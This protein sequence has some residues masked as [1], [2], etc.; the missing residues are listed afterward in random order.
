MDNETRIANAK[1]VLEIYSKDIG[2]DESN[3]RDLITDLLHL[4]HHEKKDVVR[5]LRA[6]IDNFLE[7]SNH[8]HF[9]LTTFKIET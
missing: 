9:D 3:I 2:Y 1:H 6:A 8:D 4:A 7:E 5:E